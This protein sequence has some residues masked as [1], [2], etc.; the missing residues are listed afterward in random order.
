MEWESGSERSGRCPGET[1]P[2]QRGSLPEHKAAGTQPKLEAATNSRQG[3]G[4]GGHTQWTTST[5]LAV[6][7]AFAYTSWRG[8]KE[9]P[10]TQ[11]DIWLS[12]EAFSSCV[13]PRSP[14]LTA[15]PP[16]FTRTSH[17]ALLSHTQFSVG[18]R[19][20]VPRLGWSRRYRSP[21]AAGT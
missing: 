19:T 4:G 10:V 1:V 9:G 2:D 5:R 18:V 17:S 11:G 7:R 6:T 3:R 20:L 14:S 13:G 12:L 16:P 8:Q 15:P 21:S